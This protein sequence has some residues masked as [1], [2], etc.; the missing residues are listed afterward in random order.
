[1]GDLIAQNFRSVLLK[2]LN[3]LCQLNC[4]F[5]KFVF[6][7]FNSQKLSHPHKTRIIQKLS[8]IFSVQLDC[9]IGGWN[10]QNREELFHSHPL[11]RSE[12]IEPW[13]L[14]TGLEIH[15]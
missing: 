11:F 9:R 3:S 7:L 5:V 15:P 4:I 12:V 8:P 10:Y 1:M 13:F 2:A 14:I 6:W